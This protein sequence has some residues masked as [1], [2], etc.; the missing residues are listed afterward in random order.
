MKVWTCICGSMIFTLTETETIGVDYSHEGAK[1]G[2][3]FMSRTNTKKI[4]LACVKCRAEV[5][6]MV[7]TEM[8]KGML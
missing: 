7:V 2:C 5:P 4:G 8:V 6:D 3:P 1:S